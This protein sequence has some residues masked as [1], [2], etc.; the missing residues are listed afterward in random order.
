MNN[1]LIEEKYYKELAKLIYFKDGKPYWK[2]NRNCKAKK[3]TLAGYINFHG[4]RLMCITVNGKTKRIK[5]HRLHW[6][7]IYGK[8]PKVV[9]HIN[10]DR[11]DDRIENLRSVTRSQNSINRVKLSN[12]SSIY[13]GVSWKHDINKWRVRIKINRLE[14]LIGYYDCEHCAGLAYDLEMKKIGM[15]EYAIFNLLSKDTF[16]A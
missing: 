11:S 10:R 12:S 16:N 1:K 5:S 14:K 13:K 2:V 8:I 7:M 15:E 4:Y 6:Y 9:D 3:D